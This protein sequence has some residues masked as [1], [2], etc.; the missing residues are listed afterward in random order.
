MRNQNT[1]ISTHHVFITDQPPIPKKTRLATFTRPLDKLF[2][3][4]G[5]SQRSANWKL[6][7]YTD[8]EEQHTLLYEINACVN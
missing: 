5:E 4:L 2:M 8:D 7:S 3:P 1:R 6:K